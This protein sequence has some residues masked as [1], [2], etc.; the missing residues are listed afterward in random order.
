MM[1]RRTAP[2]GGDSKASGGRHVRVA[3]S[4]VVALGVLAMAAVIVATASSGDTRTTA[5]TPKSG[6][7]LNLLGNGD[8]DYMDPNVSYYTVGQLN[9]RMWSRNLMSYPAVAGKTTDISPDLAVAPA[10]VS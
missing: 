5:T 8:V 4:G 6:G 1:L 7:T 10:K 9:M 2:H 3:R